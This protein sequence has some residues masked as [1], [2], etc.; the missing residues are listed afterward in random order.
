MACFV[1]ATGSWWM[2]AVLGYKSTACWWDNPHLLFFC[3]FQ[4]SSVS[5]LGNIWT[6]PIPFTFKFAAEIN[7]FIRRR[8]HDSGSWWKCLCAESV[9]CVCYFKF[10]INGIMSEITEHA[11]RHPLILESLRELFSFS[12]FSWPSVNTA[13]SPLLWLVTGMGGY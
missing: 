8:Q 13:A 2:V 10:I 6:F 5:Q 7:V 1:M 12:S 4:T 9:I 11:H 3:K